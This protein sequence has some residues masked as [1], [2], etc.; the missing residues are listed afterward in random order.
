MNFYARRLFTTPM[1]KQELIELR[2]NEPLLPNRN[3]NNDDTEGCQ[4]SSGDRNGVP[5]ESA[6]AENPSN[7]TDVN[8]NEDDAESQGSE[9]LTFH[10][11]YNIKISIRVK[12][13][14]SVDST[15][16]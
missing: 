14:G 2:A 1:S 12:K 5:D 8:G 10:V 4:E 16:F 11:S 7:T 3:N 6:M 15:H 9:K 13:G